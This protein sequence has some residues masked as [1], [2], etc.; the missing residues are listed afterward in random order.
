[1]KENTISPD[2]DFDNQNIFEDFTS[3]DSLEKEVK[4]H[5]ESTKRDLFY[6]LKAVSGFLK[7]I[8][9]F[10]FIIIAVF[11][12]YLYI[13]QTTSERE[14][15]FLNP[16]CFLFLWNAAETT[17]SCYSVSWYLN[18]SEENLESLKIYQTDQI[19]SLIGDIYLVDNFIYSKIVSFL[20]SISKDALNPTEILVEFD[21]LKNKFEPVDKSKIVCQ[22][23]NIVQWWILEARC[24]AYSSDWDTKVPEIKEGVLSNSTTGGTSISIASSFIEFL[25][26][27]P[28]S[29]FTLLEKQ[30]VFFS[31]NV[32]ELWVY[33]KKTPFT[34]KIQYDTGKMLKF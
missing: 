12:G 30:K 6:Y 13:Q 33:T 16:I 1:M 27:D 23:I 34:I 4:T 19:A 5:E 18:K 28:S 31:S 24:E 10:L 22:D 11:S 21:R 20:I 8:N 2:Q 32:T 7:I 15:A 17:N 26:N 9:T 25:E 14:Y 29:K 3:D